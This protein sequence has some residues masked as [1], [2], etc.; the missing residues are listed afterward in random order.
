M[1]ANQTDTRITITT[2]HNYKL[3]LKTK[4]SFNSLIENKLLRHIYN[5][6]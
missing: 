4:Q 2:Q 3:K 5:T 6:T 1:K